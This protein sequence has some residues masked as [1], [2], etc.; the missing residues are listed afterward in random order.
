MKQP[1]AMVTA[2]Y[3]VFFLAIIIFS[4][5]FGVTRAQL[6]VVVGIGLF[7]PALWE[8]V[9]LVHGLWLLFSSACLFGIGFVLSARSW[10]RLLEMLAHGGDPPY[11]FGLASTF[12]TFGALA[13]VTAAFR[14]RWK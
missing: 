12:G 9:T 3:A 4:I 5:A 2:I 8:R 11:I 7:V 1:P 10:S 6:G 14:R 13:V